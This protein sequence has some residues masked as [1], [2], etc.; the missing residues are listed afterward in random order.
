MKTEVIKLYSDREDVTLTTYILDNSEEMLN[1]IKRPLVLI[2]P[3]G[4]YL[5]C[6]DREGEPVALRFNAMGYHAAVLRYSTYFNGKLPAV[7]PQSKT[8]PMPEKERTH[9]APVREIAMAMKILADN[10]EQW[11]IDAKRIAICGFSAGSHNCAMYATHWNRPVVTDYMSCDKEI[12]RP[13]AVI[14]SYPLTDF[15][16]LKEMCETRG[17]RELYHICS[18]AFLGEFDAD[19]ATLAEVSP[20]KHVTRDTPPT[21]I[22]STAN[23]AL[24]PIRQS[25]AMAQALSTAKVP[26]A[27]HIF[28]SG[29]HGL[30]LADQ[31]S[32]TP[33]GALQNE[34]AAQWMPLCEKW[35]YK[36]FAIYDR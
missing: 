23:D 36:R 17:D 11:F 3:G 20:A 34:D 24:V 22:W 33:K 12:L 4:A 16:L 10:C 28:E 35:L 2:C 15:A 19:D 18:T 13:A 27:L 1:G 7:T 26:Y 6:S 9:P 30:S 14:L 31:A 5:G 21:F 8:L 25:L 32:A 29:P